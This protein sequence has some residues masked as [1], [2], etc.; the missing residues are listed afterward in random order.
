MTGLSER[1]QREG[2]GP[3]R[4]RLVREAPCP[5]LL[6]RRGVRPGTLAPPEA[7]TRFSWSGG[8]L[9]SAPTPGRAGSPTAGCAGRCAR[10]PGHDVR[11]D[12][13]EQRHGRRGVEHPALR[14]RPQLVGRGGI[15]RL[16]LAGPAHQCVDAR[17]AVLGV[18]R[19]GRPDPRARRRQEKVLAEERRVRRVV[20]DPGPQPDLR[21]VLRVPD[22]PEVWGHRQVAH[23]RAVPDRAQRADDHRVQRREPRFRSR[24]SRPHRRCPSAAPAGA[25]RPGRARGSPAGSPSSRREDVAAVA[26]RRARPP[27]AA[28]AAGRSI[29]RLTAR[30]ASRRSNGG[31]RVLRN[32]HEDCSV[33]RLADEPR[34]APSAAPSHAEDPNCR[35]REVAAAASIA[36]AASSASG[37][38]RASI[39]SG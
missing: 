13:A 26:A 32:I 39:T 27:K 20:G 38:R 5:V 28:T 10:V 11:A 23:P 24:A 14:P 12:R 1:W 6:V 19:A 31:T 34:I 3:A 30:R 33:R 18:V 36:F 22:F 7:L 37:R 16:R 29:A 9:I 25:P 8:R 15:A 35:P 4:T 17:I 2:I 21:P